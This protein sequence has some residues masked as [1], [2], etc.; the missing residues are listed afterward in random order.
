MEIIS[1]FNEIYTK[2]V[3]TTG[4]HNIFFVRNDRINEV[5]NIEVFISANKLPVEYLIYQ[6]FFSFDDEYTI[7]YIKM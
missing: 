3:T 1:I 5:Q 2:A 4:L 6:Y 7:F